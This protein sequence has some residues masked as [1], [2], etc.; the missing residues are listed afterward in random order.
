M[1]GDLT[2]KKLKEAFRDLVHLDN[3]NSGVTGTLKALKSGN[4]NT[5]SIFA[6]TNTASL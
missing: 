6:S 4:G 3:S 1:S 2:N 5:S